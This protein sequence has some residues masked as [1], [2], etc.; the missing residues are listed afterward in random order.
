MNQL[1]KYR[2]VYI[3]EDTQIPKE[4]TII[5]NM[6]D[7]VCVESNESDKYSNAFTG[8]LTWVCT[9][10]ESFCV[11]ATLDAVHSDWSRWVIAERNA[12]FLIKSN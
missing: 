6:A 10:H 4:T 9:H 11:R 5:I 1:Q 8:D 12:L 2:R 7:V 3:S